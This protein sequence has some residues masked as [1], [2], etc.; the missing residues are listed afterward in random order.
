MMLL[1]KLHFATRPMKW[2]WILKEK[3]IFKTGI[4]CTIHTNKSFVLTLKENGHGS[5]Y[6]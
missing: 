1:H 6:H 2:N 3:E 5:E 4:I